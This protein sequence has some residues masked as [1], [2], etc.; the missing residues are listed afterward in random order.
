MHDSGILSFDFMLWHFRS[1]ANTET[2]AL[3]SSVAAL[4]KPSVHETTNRIILYITLTLVLIKYPFTQYCHTWVHVHHLNANTDINIQILNREGGCAFSQPCTCDISYW[5]QPFDRLIIFDK[6]IQQSRLCVCMSLCYPLL[7][8]YSRPAG[9]FSFYLF[10]L[11]V[12]LDFAWA[13]LESPATFSCPV[14]LLV[15]LKFNFWLFSLL[16][17]CFHLG[18]DFEL[19]TTL[20]F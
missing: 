15:L 17:M 1:P 3:K 5:F 7:F 13:F 19:L 2:Q 6:L 11:S 20:C 4:C 14:I 9:W 18:P 12:L 8:P 16:L 10:G